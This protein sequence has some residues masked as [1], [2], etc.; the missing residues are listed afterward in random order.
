MALFQT[1]AQLDNSKI[2]FDTGVVAKQANGSVLAHLNETSVL[3]TACLEDAPFENASFFPLIVNYQEK[4]YAAG[5]IPG[6]FFKKEG[7]PKDA[8]ILCSRVIDRSI[9]PLFP[10]GMRNG[11]QVI[12]TVLS[13]DAEN[14]PDILAINAASCALTI[15]DIPFSG[16]I[17]AVRII[18]TEDKGFTVNP[19]YEEREQ[20]KLDLVVVGKDD[21]VL[22][23]EGNA[24]EIDEKTSL[25]AIKIAQKYIKEL[26]SAQQTLKEKTGK[27]KTEVPL[28][29]ENTELLNKIRERYAKKLEEAGPKKTKKEQSEVKN[30]FLKKLEE[31]FVSEE[32]SAE[33]INKTFHTAEEEIMRKKIL[34][35]KIRP[36]G[37]KPDQLRDISCEAKVFPRTHGSALFTRGE[38]Q[39]LAITTLGTTSDEQ[40][41]EALEGQ[42]YKHFMLHYSFPPFSVGE[43]SPLRGPSRREIGHGALAEKALRP[44]LPEKEDFP[45]TIRV[46]SEILESNGSSSMASVCAATLSL[47]DAGVPLQN[48]CAGIAMGLV[49]DNNNHLILA[50]IAGVEDHCG[51][52]D[53]KIAGTSKG[54][55]AI[56]LDMKIQGVEYN[57]LEEGFSLAKE[58]RS[59]ILNKMNQVLETPR[60][61]VSEFAPKIKYIKIDPDKVGALIGPGGKNIKG[62]IKEANVSVDINDDRST[63]TV[64]GETEEALSK[65]LKMVNDLIKDVEVGEIYDAKVRKITNFGAFCELLPGKDGLLHVSEISSDFVKD[66]SSVLKEGDIVKV[67][68]IK[69]DEEG[70]INLSKK[71]VDEGKD[72]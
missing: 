28:P 45:Y 41:I 7:R 66:V 2:T 20:A 67:K 46:V 58:K 52:M 47:M 14:D 57:I 10:E 48:P 24:K 69:I 31:E 65:G 21:N 43:V 11:I 61:Q 36:D 6:G 71:Q 60:K 42:S 25:E 44:L 12:A 5:K 32:V 50:D 27:E 55:T 17:G 64:A 8:E 3:T 15:S 39:S 23:L 53:F 49:K 70:R 72:N 54:I 59:Q 56:Q 13:S 30:A 38:T 26:I 19:S 4:T 16:P 33:K 18:H 62:I 37:R 9:R 22:M 34:E 40:M 63:V 29:Q 35:T 51:D 68:V 1:S